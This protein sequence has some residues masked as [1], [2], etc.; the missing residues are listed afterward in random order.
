MKQ[1][2]KIIIVLFALSSIIY[3]AP[4]TG[5]RIAIDPGHSQAS[6]GA[7]GPT[8]LQEQY[9]TYDVAVRLTNYVQYNGGGS[10][11]LTRT[12][13]SDPSLYTRQTNANTWGPSDY[14]SIH[15]NAS[16]NP[17]ANGTLTMWRYTGNATVCETLA[18]KVHAR[19]LQAT[20]LSN[21]GVYPTSRTDISP[22]GH[23]TVKYTDSWVRAILTEASF[24]TNPNEEARLKTSSYRDRLAAYI[25]WGICD[26]YGTS[27][28]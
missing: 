2:T 25:Y 8:G 19:L 13:T 26:A 24:I 21:I 12:A 27:A 3:S 6:V 1:I 14:I 16:T 15:F 11:Y 17:N 4:L 5:K 22:Y 23:N 18:R 9:V 28:W 7:V 20:G 10:W